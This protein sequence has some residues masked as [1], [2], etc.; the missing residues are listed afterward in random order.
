MA[1]FQEYAYAVSPARERVSRISSGAYAT[2]DNASEAKTGSAI[3][4]GSSVSPSCVLRSLRPSSNRL[5]MS[6]TLTTYRDSSS[7]IAAAPPHRSRDGRHSRPGRW[8]LD[9]HPCTS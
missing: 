5:P 9:S 1:I 4:L 7:P 3:R 2:E 6:E 8:S